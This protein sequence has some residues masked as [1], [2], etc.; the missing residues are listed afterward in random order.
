VGKNP[1]RKIDGAL[2]V[3]H[4]DLSHV[5]NATRWDNFVWSISS[6]TP[7]ENSSS[8]VYHT[9]IFS[10]VCGIP[11]THRVCGKRN[12]QALVGKWAA[13]Q[14]QQRNARCMQADACCACSVVQVHSRV[15]SRPSAFT[16][17]RETTSWLAL[18]SRHGIPQN[19]LLLG[20]DAGQLVT[21]Q[22]LQANGQKTKDPISDHWDQLQQVV[23]TSRQSVDLSR[24]RVQNHWV[25]C[26]GFSDQN[27]RRKKLNNN[28][29]QGWDTARVVC[30][31]RGACW[32]HPGDDMCSD[33]IMVFE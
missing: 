7:V 3:Y 23:L 27:K 32:K 8:K 24:L 15:C 18:I 10:W 28:D 6:T 26:R 25:Y 19:V 5:G 4:K 20:K 30:W 13:R 22:Q 9:Q 17:R 16:L 11:H 31:T 1:T 29:R 21:M 2:V 33:S 14:Q 12:T